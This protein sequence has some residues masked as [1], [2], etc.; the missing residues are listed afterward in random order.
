MKAVLDQ[1]PQHFKSSNFFFFFFFNYIL[2]LFLCSDRSLCCGSNSLNC[3]WSARALLALLPLRLNTFLSPWWKSHDIYASFVLDGFQI[4]PFFLLSL[5][6]SFSFPCVCQWFMKWTKFMTVRGGVWRREASSCSR[7][8]RLV[9]C[10]CAR[11]LRSNIKC[12]RSSSFHIFR[13]LL[14]IIHSSQ[15]L[16]QASWL[17][18]LPSRFWIG[19]NSQWFLSVLARSTW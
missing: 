4:S 5:F 7:M 15:L 14:H 18:Q 10:M 2:T 13:W 17:T 12:Y 8:T 11:S 1:S 19:V 9:R 6:F 16:F 3:P